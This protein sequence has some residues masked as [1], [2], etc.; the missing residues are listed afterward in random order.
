MPRLAV[1]ARLAW[2]V[3]MLNPRLALLRRAVRRAEALPD[4]RA[5]SIAVSAARDRASR[6]GAYPFAV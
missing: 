4:S 1:R 3:V 2:L 5:A 6:A